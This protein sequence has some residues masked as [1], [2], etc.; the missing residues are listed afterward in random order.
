M[1][2]NV[3]FALFSVLLSLLSPL[4]KTCSDEFLRKV[5]IQKLHFDFLQADKIF[6]GKEFKVTAFYT[7]TLIYATITGN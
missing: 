6:S 4:F 7:K 1:G 2:H 5:Q 3:Y